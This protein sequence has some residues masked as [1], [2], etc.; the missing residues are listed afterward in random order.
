[1][2]KHVLEEDK[3]TMALTHT[4]REI[5][6]VNREIE[7]MTQKSNTR[8][9]I[10]PNLLPFAVFSSSLSSSSSSAAALDLILSLLVSRISFES[11]SQSSETRSR[12][13]ERKTN[14]QI[15]KK[16]RSKEEK[17]K[18]NQ[19]QLFHI[20]NKLMSNRIFHCYQSIRRTR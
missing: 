18:K 6:T 2:D 19:R 3:H 11:S 5:Y 8:R 14:R 17:K 9:K 20:I 1:M 7:K 15:G 13:R 16:T 4:H 10:F 12:E